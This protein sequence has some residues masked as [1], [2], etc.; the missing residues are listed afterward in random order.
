MAKPGKNQD[1]Q[2]TKIREAKEQGK[3]AGK[4]GASTGA[5]KQRGADGKERGSRSTNHR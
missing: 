3:S 2:R 4:A 1:E 5:D